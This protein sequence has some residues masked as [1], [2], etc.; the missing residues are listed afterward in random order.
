[1]GKRFLLIA[2]ILALAVLGGTAKV[3]HTSEPQTEGPA[4]TTDRAEPASADDP[5]EADENAPQYY[6]LSFIGDCTLASVPYYRNSPVGF[7][8]VVGKNY[9]YPFAQTVQFFEDDDLTFAN[10]ECA[11]T[12]SNQAA[13]KT[14]LFKA[15]QDYAKIMSSGSVEFVSLANNHV[16]DYGQ[17]GYDDTL[18]A[19]EAEG[20]DWIGRDEW[21]VYELPGGLRLGVYSEFYD[22]VDEVRTQVSQLRHTDADFVIAAFHWGQEGQYQPNSDQIEK[23][24][25]AIDC[26]A[27][28]VYGSHPHTVQPIEIYKG[29]PIYYSFG[30]WIFGGN[31]NPSDTDTFFLRM[32]L[33]LYPE[34]RHVEIVSLENV[35]CAFSGTAGSNNYQPV[36]LEE[37][38]EAYERVLS[39]LGG[40][41]SGANLTISYGLGKDD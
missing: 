25:T 21:Q 7:E 36:A 9:D 10:L 35:P 8:A 30:N 12:D 29:V 23:A 16:M 18:A 15:P 40:D 31:T 19:L 34:D 20:I 24:H 32:T 2:L 26:G 38:S 11:L 28:F 5:A 13:E 4:Q 3:L 6:T 22:H 41:F 1:M 27:D 37:G 14:F 39:K 33:A 17:Q